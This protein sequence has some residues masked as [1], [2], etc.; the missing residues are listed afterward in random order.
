[1]QINIRIILKV[2]PTRK[3]NKINKYFMPCMELYKVQ[4]IEDKQPN[5]CVVYKKEDVLVQT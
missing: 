5:P 1:V 4:I 3:D 2:S